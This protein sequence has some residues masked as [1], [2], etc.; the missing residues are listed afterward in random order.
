[1]S[2]VGVICLGVLL[3]IVL[4]E[5]KMTKY[6]RGVFS[7]IVIIV[8]VSPL[9]SLLNKDWKFELDEYFKIDADYQEQVGEDYKCSVERQIIKALNNEGVNADI[10][11][12]MIG[13]RIE[14]VYVYLER[15][16]L[17]SDQAQSMGAKNI[18]CQKLS[19]KADSII[20][21]FI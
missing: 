21:I 9:P 6:I 2:I 3:E 10:D 18:I 13:S 1:M 20:V 12:E 11:V 19:I 4:P 15:N 17:V 5:G 16:P 8:I 7:L 14:R